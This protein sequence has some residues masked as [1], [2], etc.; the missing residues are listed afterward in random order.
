MKLKTQI[1]AIIATAMAGVILVSTW[2]LVSLRQTLLDERKAQIS[3]LLV[4]SQAMLEHYQQLEKNGELA[5]E[6]AQL[7]A[8]QA[9][10]GLR[11]GDDYVVVRTMDNVLL[12]HADEKRIGNVDKGAQLPDG[13]YVADHY[14]DILAKAESGFVETMASR[15]GQKDGPKVPKLNGIRKFEPWG[16]MIGYGLFLDDIDSA[17]RVQALQFLALS[18]VVLT[19]VAALALTMSKRILGQIGGE[20]QHAALLSHA[21]AKGDLTQ[22]IN[23][24]AKGESLLASLAD[25]QESLRRMVERFNKASGLLAQAATVIST[26]MRDIEYRSGESTESTAATAASIEQMVTSIGVVSDNAR[27]AEQFSGES[28][29]LAGNGQQLAGEASAAIAA[30]STGVQGAVILVQGLDHHSKK[31]DAI[32]IVIN[33]IAEQTNLLAL[34]AAIE[35]A[36][37]GEQGRGF[38]VVADEVR[39]L[40]ERTSE[41]TRNIF[42]VTKTVQCDINAAAQEMNKIEDLVANGVARTASAAESLRK[43]SASTEQASRRV[44]EVTTAMQEQRHASESIAKNV[45]TI[46]NAIHESDASLR[47]ISAAFN[48]LDSLAKDLQ[49][50]AAAFRI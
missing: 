27:S 11:K 42:D 10:A 49:E 20:P 44:S 34:N 16:W 45:E 29:A 47:E 22:R 7:R 13:R 48:D 33:E 28:S 50:A 4:L 36:R 21:I 39:K 2:S 8:K 43:I 40:A 9:L 19:A 5:H 38:A 1:W 26:K 32:A 41:A 12:V 24:D 30:V 46:A 14:R 31:I 6:E 25:M 3:G 37:A 15:P 17:F 35:A 23:V 18:V